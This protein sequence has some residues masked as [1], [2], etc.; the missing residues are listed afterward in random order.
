M[1]WRD[2]Y[3]NANIVGRGWGA[4]RM[5]QARRAIRYLRVGIVALAAMAG[6]GWLPVGAQEQQAPQKQDSDKQEKKGRPKLFIEIV[7]GSDVVNN[8]KQRVAREPQVV[9]YDENHNP[10]NGAEVTF[11]L[12]K[13]GPGAHFPGGQTSYTTTTGANGQATAP[14]LQANNVVGSF[15]INVVVSSQ[16]STVTSTIP[17]ANV[18]A[19]TV[20]AGTSVLTTTIITATT[21]A[22]VAGATAGTILATNSG[23]VSPSH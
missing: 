6:A 4:R 11:L 18:L 15:K 13:S 10:V 23:Q 16:G 2:G 1:D 7:Q 14:G 21:V 17:M 5:S 8:V 22:G 9:V 19:A 3:N 20:A 12:P